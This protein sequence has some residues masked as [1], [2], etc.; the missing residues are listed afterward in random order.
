MPRRPRAMPAP[1][2]MVRRQAPRRGASWRM[3]GALNEPDVSRGAA[4][5]RP[6]GSRAMAA[7]RPGGRRGRDLSRPDAVPDLLL[8]L[9]GRASGAAA[10]GGRGAVAAAGVPAEAL[11]SRQSRRVQTAAEGPAALLRRAAAA[12]ARQDRGAESPGRHLAD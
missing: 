11:T 1:A 5:P 12:A 4:R 10:E 6:P 9:A 2:Q 3:R 7:R 8:R